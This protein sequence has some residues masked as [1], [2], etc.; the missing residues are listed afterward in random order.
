MNVRT[1]CTVLCLSVHTG[2]IQ[3][4]TVISLLFFEILILIVNFQRKSA[5]Y[6][7]SKRITSIITVL[8]G[9]FDVMKNS[10]S[11]S[12]FFC[13]LRSSSIDRSSR[14]HHHQSHN[15]HQSHIYHISITYHNS[16]IIVH[17]TTACSISLTTQIDRYLSHLASFCSYLTT[18]IIQQYTQS[19]IYL[20][21]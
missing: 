17:N 6:I 2:M 20:Q 4:C 19:Y 7:E 11:H 1:S 10:T 16:S 3:Y 5:R 12:I 8:I 18:R 14:N 15:H 13:S 9:V 21:D